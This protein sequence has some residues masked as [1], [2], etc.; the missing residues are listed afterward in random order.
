M[1][2]ASFFSDYAAVMYPSAVAPDIASA[3]S[4]MSKSEVELQ[5]VLGNEQTMFALWRDPFFPAYYKDLPA[6]QMDLHESRLDAEEAETSLMHAEALGADPTTIASLMIGSELLDYAGQKFQTP[7]EMSQLWSK[8]GPR[9][10]ATE[11]WWNNWGSQITYQDHSRV[12][13]LMDRITDLRPAYREDWLQEYTPYR[14]GSALGRWDAEYQYWRGV[15]QKLQ[16]FDDRS[17]AGDPLPP[18]EK[19]IEGSGPADSA[20]K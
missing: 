13:D 5:K 7:V 8:L 12:V 16:E 10:P 18:L 6:H 15:Q 1:D 14:L 4:N 19:I 17:Q 11:D 2:R 9:R 3:I 20:S